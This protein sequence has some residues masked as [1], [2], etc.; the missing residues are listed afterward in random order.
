MGPVAEND[1]TPDHSFRPSLTTCKTSGCHTTATNFNVKNGQGSTR[2]ALA[3]FQVILNG[4]NALTR[5]IP[6]SLGNLTPALSASELGDGHYE[7]DKARTGAVLTPD[8]AGALYNYFLISRGSGW[9][10]HNPNYVNQLLFDSIDA[11][12]GAAKP[13]SIADPR[14]PPP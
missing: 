14:T 7:L 9:G 8:Q 12:N 11:I 6:D 13:A 10:V 1:N 2:F 4:L 3:E 5:G